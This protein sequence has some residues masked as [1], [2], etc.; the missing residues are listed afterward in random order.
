MVDTIISKHTKEEII[1][2]IP[3]TQSI[4]CISYS[5]LYISSFSS[6]DTK[7]KF[8]NIGGIMLLLID[9]IKKSFFIQIYSQLNLY[10]QFQIEIYSNI[11]ITN[12][13]HVLSDKF[14]AI[15]YPFGYLGI[16]FADKRHAE[17]FKNN[18]FSYSFIYEFSN[19]KN[20]KLE[21]I[22]QNTIPSIFF[23]EREIKQFQIINDI[24]I[25]YIEP[26]ILSFKQED[27]K[28]LFLDI[29]SSEL[30]S[31]GISINQIESHFKK[32]KNQM[33]KEIKNNT[34]PRQF[35]NY[36]NKYQDYD[37]YMRK[38]LISS[39][40][41]PSNI[42]YKYD[43]VSN[44]RNEINDTNLKSNTKYNYFAKN[45]Q[46]KENK[47]LQLIN[48]EID[49]EISFLQKESDSREMLKHY[50]HIFSNKKHKNLDYSDLIKFCKSDE[51]DF[52]ESELIK[53]KKI[54][55]VSNENS[56]VRKSIFT[57]FKN[58][59]NMKLDFKKE[60]NEIKEDLENSDEMSLEIENEKKSPTLNIHNT[61][62]SPNLDMNSDSFNSEFKL[63]PSSE[64]EK[65]NELNNVPNENKDLVTF[66]KGSES[67]QI[68]KE[69]FINMLKPDNFSHRT[70]M[71]KSIAIFERLKPYKNNALTKDNLQ[72]EEKKIADK[73]QEIPNKDLLTIQLEGKENYNNNYIRNKKNIEENLS[74]QREENLIEKYKIEPF[75]KDAKISEVTNKKQ[76]LDQ[77][78]SIRELYNQFKIIKENLGELVEE[79]EESD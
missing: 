58:A 22:K 29:V 3:K 63:N 56:K 18:V 9:R 42:F 24:N 5:K 48:H 50:T 45:F 19:N 33:N 8:T 71:K 74:I 2:Q 39:K 34:V 44:V 53:I 60:E 38:Q 75:K 37:I 13:Y 15:Q 65:K 72:M 32:I 57:E 77:V 61:P 36:N 35:T 76:N 64:I 59:K 16:N 25:S 28:I 10:I 30:N 73:F 11:H 54:E 43:Y 79:D 69:R 70:G 7:F 1:K 6:K 21:P 66:E 20:L 62:F 78:K 41:V 14:H 4:L 55:N 49:K 40:I 46:P 51:V 26:C 27:S 67:N 23:Y 17:I 31:I 68:K 12:S 47:V 52:F